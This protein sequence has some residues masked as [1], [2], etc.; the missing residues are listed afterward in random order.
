MFVAVSRSWETPGGRAGSAEW[1]GAG[2]APGPAEA[3]AA[4]GVR[5]PGPAV[6]RRALPVPQ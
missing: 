4:A 2:A 1:P 3:E 6:R 5:V